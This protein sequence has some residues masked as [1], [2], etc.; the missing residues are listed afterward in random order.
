MTWH[1]VYQ[2]ALA[3][4]RPRQLSPWADCGGVGAALVTD[5]GAVYTGVCVDTSCSMGFCAEHA[6]AAAMLTAGE[7]RVMMMVAVG[8]DGEILPPC[9]RCREFVSQLHRDNGQTEVLLPGRRVATLAT[10]LPNDWKQ[11]GTA[12]D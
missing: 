11:L 9:G 8:S 6:A 10:L 2:A 5:T 4:V 7:Q 1:E 12:A 3:V